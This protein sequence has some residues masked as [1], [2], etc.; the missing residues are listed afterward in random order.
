MRKLLL[1]ATLFQGIPVTIGQD[2]WTIVT[3]KSFPA[4]PHTLDDFAT[5]QSIE[6]GSN[7]ISVPT[8]N[9]PGAFDAGKMRQDRPLPHSL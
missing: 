9:A 3:A 5:L 2:T 6:K 4:F 8:P 7:A 1:R